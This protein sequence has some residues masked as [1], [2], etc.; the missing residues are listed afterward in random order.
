MFRYILFVGSIFLLFGCGQESTIKELKLAHGLDVTHPVHKGI[1]DFARRVEEKSGGNLTVRIYPNGQ[2]GNER[3][4]LEL[5]QIGSVAITKVSAAVMENFVPSYR[6]LGLPYLFRDGDHLFDVLEGPIGEDLLEQG[7]RFRLRGL[8]FYDAGS[9]SFYTKDVPVN[10]PEDLDGLKLR[11]MKSNTAVNMVTALGGS[12]TPIS[13]GELYTA[14]Q[15]GV[16]DG[17]E[18]NPPSFYSA[19]HYEVCKYY[20]LDEHTMVPDVLLISTEWW[21]RLSEEEK[22]WVTE[23][24]RES[25]SYQRQVWAESVQESLKKVQEAGVEIIYPDKEKFSRE[26][27]SIHESYRDQPELYKMITDIKKTGL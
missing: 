2:L 12:P 17:A 11:V 26:V 6:V 9:R 8:C 27:M 5:L 14:L 20:S 3:E 22:T 18:N 16:V 13:F 4:C 23:A 1:V 7:G 15:Q 10:S 25:V 19:R 21:D 24:A